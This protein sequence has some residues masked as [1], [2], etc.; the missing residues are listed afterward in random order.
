MYLLF[1][2][3]SMYE[4]QGPFALATLTISGEG[5][6]SNNFINILR[7]KITFQILN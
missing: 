4:Y 2:G 3:G 1:T 5:T 7:N 6:A